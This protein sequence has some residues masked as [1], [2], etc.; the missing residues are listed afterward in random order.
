MFVALD[1]LYYVF[2]G[3]IY[4]YKRQ[5][6]RAGYFAVLTVVMKFHDELTCLLHLFSNNYYEYK[7]HD[8]SSGR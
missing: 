7:L 4:A 6:M 8:D 1:V 5:N 2:V 3:L